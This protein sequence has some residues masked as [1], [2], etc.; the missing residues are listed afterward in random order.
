MARVFRELRAAEDKFPGWPT[1]PVHAG[2]IVA[3]E[4]GE[5]SQATLQY[6]YGSRRT[7]VEEMRKEAAHTA[8][9]AIRFLLGLQIHGYSQDGE[10]AEV[11]H[12]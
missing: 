4:A 10:R 11:E 12:V 1:D 5:L 3:E 9:M 2:A 7:S 8:A 6:Y